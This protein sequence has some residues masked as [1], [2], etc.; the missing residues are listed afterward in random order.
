MRIAIICVVHVLISLY[1]LH[2][3]WSDPHELFTPDSS[4]YHQL[5]VNIISHNEFSLSDKAPFVPDFFRTPTYP[6]FLAACYAI[7]GQTPYVPVAIQIVLNVITIL[8]VY[9]IAQILFSPVAAYWSSALLAL[10]GVFTLHARY[11]LTETLFTFL[12][13]V[14]MYLLIRL[15]YSDG[16]TERR[17]CKNW[18]MPVCIGLILGVMTLC[19]PNGFYFT[20]LVCIAILLLVQRVDL[21]TRLQNAAIIALVFLFAI[22]PWA[23]RNWHH[24]GA[25]KLDTNQSYVLY[26]VTVGSMEARENDISLQEAVAKRKAEEAGIEE[27][28]ALELSS[29]RQKA[30]VAAIL[31]KPMRFAEVFLFGLA[32]TLTPISPKAMALY[33]DGGELSASSAAQVGVAFQGGK[34]FVSA[35]AQNISGFRGSIWLS[36]IFFAI[37]D[38]AKYGLCIL[39]FVLY[40]VNDRKETLFLLG[41]VVI[42]FLLITGPMGPEATFRYRTPIEPYMS[43]LAGSGVAYWLRDNRGIRDKRLWVAL[44]GF[45]V[46]GAALGGARLFLS[47]SMV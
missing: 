26:F 4:G 1:Y 15:I 24:Q 25:L 13:A 35:I 33:I 7:F 18:G 20:F 23:I 8:V 30:A 10:S 36:S 47:I 19:R 17:L 46:F 40:S 11:L 38:L 43:L 12:L 27:L 44:A 37:V 31:D 14:V 2:F 45:L 42:Y 41:A 9:R 22:S 39:A 32:V 34:G 5:A 29:R 21:Y 6:L 16:H 28:S 3:A